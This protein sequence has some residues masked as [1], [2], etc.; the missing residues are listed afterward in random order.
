V[1]RYLKGAR[2]ERELLN[3][4]YDNGYSVIRAAGSGVNALGPD[5]IAVKD[6]F[7][8]AFECKAWERNRLSIDLEAYQKLREWNDNTKFPTYIAWRMNGK[9][10]F[11]VTLDELKHGDKDHSI[12]KVRTFEINRLFDD[13]IKKEVDLKQQAPQIIVAEMEK[14]LSN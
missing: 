3:R 5:I 7:C 4:L 9:G 2:S 12:T 6:R 10:W 14:L 8:M 11:F 13:I 1:H